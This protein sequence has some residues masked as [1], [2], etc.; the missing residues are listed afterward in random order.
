[1]SPKDH[2]SSLPKVF[3]LLYWLQEI[4]PSNQIRVAAG[5]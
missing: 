4:R 5:T 1:M 3:G 2:F